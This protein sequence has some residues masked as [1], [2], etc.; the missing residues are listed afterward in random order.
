MPGHTPCLSPGSQT[1]KL[2]RGVPE[3]TSDR[4]A[5]LHDWWNLAFLVPVCWL[6]WC[7]W[8]VTLQGLSRSLAGDYMALPAMWT[9]SHFMVQQIA[10]SNIAHPSL[11][12]H[13]PLTFPLLRASH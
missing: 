8:S 9:G 12:P 1:F 13:P 11:L 6:N 10:L 2:L 3:P 5:V 7:N 4:A